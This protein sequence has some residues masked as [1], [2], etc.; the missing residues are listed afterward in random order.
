MTTGITA[1][2]GGTPQ[3]LP[4]RLALVVLV[5]ITTFAVARFVTFDPSRSASRPTTAPRVTTTEQ[6]IATL[7]ASTRRDP[8]NASTW[9]QLGAAYLHRAIETADPAFYSLSGRA[10]DRADQLVPGQPTTAVARGA[11][12]LSLHEFGQA[13]ALVEPIT[14]QDPFDSDALAVLVDADVELGRYEDAATNLQRLLDL[15]PGLPAYSRASYLRELHGDL[16][17]AEQAMHQALTAGAGDRF[18]VATVTTFLGDLAFGSGDVAGAG[19]RYGEALRDR[20]DHVN[21]TLGQARVLAARGERDRAID[22][23]RRLTERVPLP[24]AVI[25]LGDLQH[26]A[27]HPADA[28]RSFDLVRSI[29]RLQQASGAVTD[30]ETALFEAD[31]GDPGRALAAAQAAYAA[32][33]DNVYTADALAWSLVQSGDARAAQ[34]LITE[35]LRLGSVDASIHY[36]A[37]VIADALGDA[38][39]ARRELTYTFTRNPFFTFSQ[40]DS[41]SALATRLGIPTPKAWNA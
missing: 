34:P 41:A 14:G 10:L 37:A 9:Q 30:L 39:G 4:R 17:G 27:G 20:P 26:A 19:A 21:A 36:H 32:R 18:D 13:R 33:P 28:A 40:R 3:V 6:K 29:V 15:R 38:A 1:V 8:E 5:A 25:L 23:L 11:L 16:A 22:V 35:A 2:G 24:A 31:H 12:L 7:E